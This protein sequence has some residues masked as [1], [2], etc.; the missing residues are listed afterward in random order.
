M[1]FNALAIIIAIISFVVGIR[2]ILK[3]IWYDTKF[4]RVIDVTSYKWPLGTLFLIFGLVVV[5]SEY[6][7]IKRLDDNTDSSK[8]EE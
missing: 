1:K 5:W 3:P 2:V 4:M 6:R 7:R 8:K